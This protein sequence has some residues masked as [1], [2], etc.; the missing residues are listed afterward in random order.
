MLLYQACTIFYYNEIN[1]GFSGLGNFSLRD[2][3]AAL[4]RSCD[5]F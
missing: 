3:Y 5:K 2:K 4:T 1:R